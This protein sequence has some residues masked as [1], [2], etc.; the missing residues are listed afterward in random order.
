MT[1]EYRPDWPY[2]LRCG[3]HVADKTDLD[4]EVVCRFCRGHDHVETPG[5]TICS[6]CALDALAET[7]GRD[8]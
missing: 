1:N 3:V 4:G 7:A 2:C 5:T 8:V 6:E